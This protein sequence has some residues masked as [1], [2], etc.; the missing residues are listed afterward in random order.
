MV[1][2]NHLKEMTLKW[3]NFLDNT[4]SLRFRIAVC[5]DFV[6]QQ[7]VNSNADTQ[8]LEYGNLTIKKQI[9]YYRENDSRWHL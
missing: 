6:N 3:F 8:C 5:E 7:K 1:L 9:L 4:D 2:L